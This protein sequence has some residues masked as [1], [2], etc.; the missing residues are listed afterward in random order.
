VNA[1]GA[2]IVLRERTTLD[3]L[4]LA[5]LF[6]RQRGR[7]QY[8]NLALLSLLPSWLVLLCLWHFADL[9]WGWIW[10]A[11]LA[12]HTL[13][14]LPFLV[15]SG[16]LLFEQNPPLPA[17]CRAALGRLPAYL[18]TQLLVFI[19]LVASV[20]TVVGPGVVAT[21]YC[22][23]PEVLVLEGATGLLALRRSQQFLAR[24]SGAGLAMVGLRLTLLIAFV[25]VGELLGQAG[26]SVLLDVH[27]EVP[28]LL[29]D[30]GSPFALAGLLL[31]VPLTA[32]FRFL[33]YVSERTVQDGW[34]VQ[35]AL[36]ALAS[37]QRTETVP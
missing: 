20:L 3:V 23:V 12:F 17:A 27:L 10:F 7:R 33:S 15:L 37:E 22:F 1:L 26:L 16:R 14:E 25:G 24:R 30:G 6:C 21:V 36:L 9:A 34:D 35:V 13:L 4:D 11:A 32:T 28:Q 8:L 2:A 31:S 29:E 18:G 5:I 19:V